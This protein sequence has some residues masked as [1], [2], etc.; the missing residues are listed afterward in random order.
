ML[1]LVLVYQMALSKTWDLYAQNITL[2][3]KLEN[4]HES[5]KNKEVVEQKQQY[6]EQRISSFFIDSISHQDFLIETLTHYCHNNGILLQE[7]PAMTSH[8]EGD[9]L[10]GTYKVVLEGNY[11]NLLKLV[12]LLE[13]KNKIGRVSSVSFIYKF[14]NKRKKNVLSMYLY[15]QNIQLH[16]DEKQS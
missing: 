14:D 13:Q 3:E 6:L 2:A 7:L 16:A 10:V 9:F 15:I 12:Y 8:Q 1:F 5:E 11:K 4:I